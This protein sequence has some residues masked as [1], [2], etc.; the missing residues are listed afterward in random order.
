MN[1]ENRIE[2]V[3]A[4]NKVLMVIQA[5]MFSMSISAKEGALLLA[6][7]TYMID[8]AVDGEGRGVVYH[9]DRFMRTD[10]AKSVANEST[11]AWEDRIRG[12]CK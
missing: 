11:Q 1:V 3:R 4:I 5:G 2:V 8:H 12:L 6:T 10:W 9:L 7:L